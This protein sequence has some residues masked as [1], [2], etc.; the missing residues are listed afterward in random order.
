MPT[1]AEL[2]YLFDSPVPIT[3]PDQDVVLQRLHQVSVPRKQWK[4]LFIFAFDHR[5]QLVELAHKGGRGLSAISE[6]K[7][8]FIQ[9]VER[10]E[11][12]LKRQ[13]IGRASVRERGCKDV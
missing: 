3:R 2:D 7:Q 6:L 10:V 5:W 1:R 8:L 9:A 11:T 12:D 13:E 4:Q